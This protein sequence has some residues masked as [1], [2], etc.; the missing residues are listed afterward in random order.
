MRV[1]GI[2]VYNPDIDRLQKNI[3]A[4]SSQIDFLFLYQNS[5]VGDS[6]RFDN[7]KTQLLNDGNNKG[8]ATGLNAI[9]Q[10]ASEKGADWCLLLDQDS[11]VSEGYVDVMEQHTSLNK[12]SIL[13]PRVTDVNGNEDESYENPVDEV[14]MCIT[15]GSY[16]SVSAWK[17]AGR[18][19]DEFFIDYVDWE[20]CARVR[21]K[22]YK[23]Y[24]INELALS[25][26]LGKR[27]YHS[28]LGKRLYTF[29]H[30][31]FRKYYITRN[32]IVTYRLYPK[33][34]EL[35]HP[36]L[37]TLKR[38]LITLLYEKEKANKMKAILR[39]VRDS[40]KLYHQ[41]RDIERN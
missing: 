20:Y 34:R 6:I 2:V 41:L 14:R 37:R 38:L 10:A 8:I 1:A 36:Y 18:F 13:T 12:A 29:N 24:R 11:V 5:N 32:T 7:S 25:H 15:S 40:G 30:S 33:E 22:D 39:G 17:K 9:M 31:A 28:F 27:T 4:V 16:N 21:S 23:V 35:Q 26:E 19:I 3:D